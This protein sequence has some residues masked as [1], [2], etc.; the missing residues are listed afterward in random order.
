MFVRPVLVFFAG[1]MG[2]AGVAAAAAGAHLPDVPN[3]PVAAQFLL[4]HAAAVVALAALSAAA[5]GRLLAEIAAIVL[6]AGA[7]LFSGSLIVDDLNAA[8]PLAALAPV[9]GTT[10]IAGWLLVS[11]AGLALFRR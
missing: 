2:A 4:F 9:G 10:L 5:G 11:V 8:R 6:M 7:G 3:L 1:L